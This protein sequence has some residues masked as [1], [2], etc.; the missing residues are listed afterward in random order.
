MYTSSGLADESAT[1]ESK[2]GRG[3][4]VWWANGRTSMGFSVG[5]LEAL[6]ERRTRKDAGKLA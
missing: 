4:E 2:V 5:S 3:G 1:R 6:K